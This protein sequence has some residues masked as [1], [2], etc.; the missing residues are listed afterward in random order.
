MPANNPSRRNDDGDSERT[1]QGILHT[2]EVSGGLW[3]KAHAAR[4][5]NTQRFRG[6]LL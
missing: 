3:C 2:A 1:W 4:Q 5:R 6:L